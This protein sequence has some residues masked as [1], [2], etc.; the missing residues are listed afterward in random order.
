[1][2]NLS[3]LESGMNKAYRAVRGMLICLVLTWV[4]SLKLLAAFGILIFCVFHMI[5]LY[6]AGKD[7]EGCRKAFIL[8]VVSVIMAILSVFPLGIIRIF[9]TLVR[10]G[11]EFLTV[12]LACTSVSEATDRIGAANVRREGAMAWQVNAVCYGLIA[13]CTLLSGILY[14]SAF[15]M[16]TTIA[17]M[18]IPLLAKVFYM[19]FLKECDQALYGGK[20]K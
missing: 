7:I 12:Y 18:L 1:M 4:P 20:N 9:A 14:M 8:S 15:E 10:C 17:L 3:N 16:L 11:T 5:G 2:E 19:L 13:L 6:E